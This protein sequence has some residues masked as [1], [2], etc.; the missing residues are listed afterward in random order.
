MPRIFDNIEKPLLP[1]L[2]DTIKV[3]ERADFCVGYFNLR[4]W[5]HLAAHIDRWE[6]GDNQCCRLLVGMHVSPSDELRQVLGSHDE[7]DRLDNQTALREKRRIAEEFRQQLTFGAPNNND[8]ASLRKCDVIVDFSEL[9]VIT[10][11]G[12]L[13]QQYSASANGTGAATEAELETKKQALQTA[14][15]ALAAAKKARADAPAETAAAAQKTPEEK[16]TAV[17][18]TEKD[19]VAARESRSKSTLKWSSMLTSAFANPTGEVRLV[20]ATVIQFDGDSF[21][22]ITEKESDRT[23]ALAAHETAVASGLETRRAIVEFFRDT[24]TKAIGR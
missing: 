16:T 23:V 7:D 1:A 10:L 5:S 19:Y 4:G 2:Q 3:A 9:E 15:N 18:A 13:S 24:I 6:G 12:T 17:L 8:E 21:K 20:A 14:S 11:T 22:F